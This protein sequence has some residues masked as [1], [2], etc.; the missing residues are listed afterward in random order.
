MKYNPEYIHNKY[1][2]YWAIAMFAFLVCGLLTVY[3][4]AGGFWNGYVLDIVGPAWNY[5][6]IRGL[7]TGFRRNK[8]TRFFTPVK[9]FFLI[10]LVSYGIETIQ[11]FGLYDS[12][13][14][15]WDLL[16]YISLLTPLFLIDLYL[17]SKTRNE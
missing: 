5:I 9:A 6:L 2:P 7:F 17:K 4:K 15:P 13:F 3:I 11:Y 1:A 14:D 10:F 12:T 16:S 8:W